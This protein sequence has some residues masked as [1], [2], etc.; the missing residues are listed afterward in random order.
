M[1]RENSDEID[2]EYGEQ[3]DEA[4]WAERTPF[5]PRIEEGKYPAMV[6]DVTVEWNKLGSFGY[7][8]V[9]ALQFDV[10]GVLL[11]HKIYCT[12]KD[13]GV[14]NLNTKKLR[15]AMTSILGHEPN[16]KFNL[17]DLI[18]KPCEVWIIHVNG[19]NGDIF[20]RVE[21]IRPAKV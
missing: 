11:N 8:D 2:Q 19:N 17:K 21:K 7:K 10:N 5:T 3:N 1:V 12:P 15:E 14:L 4:I 18:G 20:E 6:N 9:V 13:S 16:G